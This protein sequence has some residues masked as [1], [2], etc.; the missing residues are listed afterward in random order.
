MARTKTAKRKPSARP[1]KG[2]KKGPKKGASAKQGTRRQPK[3]ERSK[4]LVDAILTATAQLLRELGSEQ[5]TT[6]KIAT[7]AGV[8]IGSLYQY[9]PNKAELYTALAERH[10]E[11]LEG[12]LMPLLRRF[13]ETP[14]LDLVHALVE[15]L[16]IME[17][18][19]G[20]LHAELLRLS[21]WSL[22]S[23]V[24]TDFRQRAEALLAQLLR[25]R[26]DALPRPLADPEL[27]AR[28]LVRALGGVL[29][30]QLYEHPEGLADPALHAELT[31]LVGAYLGFPSEPSKSAK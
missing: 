31:A 29:D 9:F 18:T 13:G 20:R 15:S 21:L 1:P 2:A 4:A 23:E 11:R 14:D 22:T 17:S 5:V 3:Q 10:V 7:R 28:I 27:S 12:V 30:T 8:S 25:E 24:I 16:M 19:D 26:A 6:N